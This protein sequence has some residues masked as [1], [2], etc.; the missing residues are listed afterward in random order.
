MCICVN[1][2]HVHI[3]NTYALIKKQHSKSDFQKTTKFIPTQTII[4]INIK[5]SLYNINFDWDLQECLSF[6]EKPGQ[7]LT[8]DENKITNV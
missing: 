8:K 2:N 6:A 4:H 3:C 5:S 7:W 1:C